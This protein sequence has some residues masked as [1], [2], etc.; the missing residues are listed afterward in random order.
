MIITRHAVDRL[1]ERFPVYRKFQPWYM[2]RLLKRAATSGV[3]IGFEIR[4]RV[5]KLFTD[6]KTGEEIVVAVDSGGLVKT[7]LNRKMV[8]E[9]IAATGWYAALQRGR[10]K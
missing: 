5:F 9:S 2:N 10:R 6:E 3:Q 1:I 7:V 8:E 4:G